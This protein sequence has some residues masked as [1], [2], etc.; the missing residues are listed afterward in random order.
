MADNWEASQPPR[1]RRKLN[2]KAHTQDK[3]MT[4]ISQSFHKSL[5]S[6]ALSKATKFPTRP[7]FFTA[8]DWK[9][10]SDRELEAELTRR[11]VS[12]WKE[13]DYPRL[14]YTIG[15]KAYYIDLLFHLDI[16]E[17]Q[18]QAN[19][20][21]KDCDGKYCQGSC[22]HSHFKEALA[23]GMQSCSLSPQ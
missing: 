5:S 21:I 19:K 14:S 22:S 20:H 10:A 4:P 18:E 23:S 12:R 11:G 15:T 2:R 16:K 17:E 8:K 1:K 9:Y 13:Q 7:R 3:Q 6:V